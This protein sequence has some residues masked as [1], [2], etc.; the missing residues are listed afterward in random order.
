M[1]MECVLQVVLIQAPPNVG[2]TEAYVQGG[3]A[4]TG[5]YKHTMPVV[6]NSYPNTH[7]SNV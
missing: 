2:Q 7:S 5:A 6:H 3:A 1:L 4:D